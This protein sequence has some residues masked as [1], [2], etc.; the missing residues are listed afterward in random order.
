MYDGCV[1]GATFTIREGGK[2]IGHGEVKRRW[3]ETH[4]EEKTA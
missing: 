4:D 2:I 3:V 1:P